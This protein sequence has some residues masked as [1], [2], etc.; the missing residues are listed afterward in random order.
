MGRSESS[1]V[2]RG[3]TEWSQ[4]SVSGVL[5]QNPE[6]TLSSVT[7]VGGTN[8]NIGLGVPFKV[9]CRLGIA[10]NS[11]AAATNYDAD[12]FSKNAPFKFRVLG[13]QMTTIDVTAAE[14][15][16]ADAGALNLTLRHGDGAASETF[17]NIVDCNFDENIPA[18]GF[19]TPLPRAATDAWDI[20]EAVIG[21]GESLQVRLTLDPDATAGAT[22]DGCEVF[23]ELDCL[24][25]N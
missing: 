20:D 5:T 15:G 1:L 14:F 21:E 3:P 24:R 19:S 12:V 13:G 23:V 11:P 25:V 7:E 4:D 9:C 22:N 10:A 17:A 6:S 18:N 2:G 16:A 8:G